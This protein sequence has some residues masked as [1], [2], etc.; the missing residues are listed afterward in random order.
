MSKYV[1]GIDIGT[2]SLKGILVDQNGKVIA[3]SAAPYKVY[4]PYKGYS[5]QNPE[6][7]YL[8]TESVFDDF[9]KR[10]DDF[11]DNLEGIAFSGQMH[12]LVLLDENM[13]V[14]RNAILWNDTRST[15]QCDKLMK[16]YGE[17]LLF[18]T[19]NKALEGFTL[20]KIMWVQENEPELWS[21]VRHIL[22]PK[23]YVR[24][25]LTGTLG[26]DLSDASGTLLLDMESNT[27]S[28]N[29]ISNYNIPI[30]Y[31]PNLL[32]SQ[33]YVGKLKGSISKKYKFLNKI[34][35]FAGGADNA[36]AALGAGVLS[37]DTGLCSIGTSGVILGID[38]Y[39]KT[40]ADGKIHHFYHT[41][42][43][44]IYSMGVTLAAG[45]ALSWYKNLM[46]PTSSFDELLNAS[47]RIAIGAAGL[48]F[49][50]YID[51]ERTPY[52]DS[53]IRGSFIGI[54]RH[55]SLPHFTRAVVEGITY[56]LKDCLELM[57]KERDSAFKEIVSIGGGARSDYWLQMQADIFNKEI[58]CLEEEQGPAMGAAMLAAIGLNW[59]LSYEQIIRDWV[60]IKRRFVPISE[61]VA[62]YQEIYSKYQKVYKASKTVM[63]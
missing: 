59:Y 27:W 51:G 38:K 60:K 45:S 24:F 61:N 15:K 31:L 9:C 62:E 3:D 7:W 1:L 50:P 48:L 29:I 37:N 49:S 2:S 18:I 4:T 16:Y 5:E 46:T 63:S 43:S 20:P 25:R 44:T 14:V 12:S 26:I 41:I 40:I 33:Q 42:P 30:D 36:C 57:E 58:V 6:D 54:D 53:K 32:K 35:V 55:H 28:K 23:D 56:S 19:K 8:A 39:K 47:K 13:D 21:K 52:S 10:V 11:A 22:L 17:E 34:D